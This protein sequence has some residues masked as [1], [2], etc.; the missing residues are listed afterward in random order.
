MIYNPNLFNAEDDVEKFLQQLEMK[1]PEQFGKYSKFYNIATE[2]IRDY[3]Q[4][5]NEKWE[6]KYN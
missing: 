3:V 2:A 1:W 4:A 6:Y 5:M